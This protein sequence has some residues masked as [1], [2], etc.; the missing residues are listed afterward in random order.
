MIM[1]WDR[2]GY[3]VWAGLRNTGFIHVVQT[4]AEGHMLTKMQLASI[5]N[6]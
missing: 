1:R 3:G 4:T 2:V 5:N 6:A